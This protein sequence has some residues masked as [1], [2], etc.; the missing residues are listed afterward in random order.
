MIDWLVAFLERVTVEPAFG[1]L[2]LSVPSR[3]LELT[4]FITVGVLPMA[5]L[6][7]GLW[8]WWRR[9]RR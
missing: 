7:V 6:A 3:D 8:V 5:I 2:P 1:Q 9:A 4:A